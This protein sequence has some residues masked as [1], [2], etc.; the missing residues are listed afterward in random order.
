MK[1]SE[2]V[3]GPIKEE[4]MKVNHEVIIFFLEYYRYL[5]RLMKMF[6]P[7]ILYSTDT[8]SKVAK[9]LL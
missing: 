4:R 8:V 2:I 7:V 3:Q 5:P 1:M 9:G 6:H